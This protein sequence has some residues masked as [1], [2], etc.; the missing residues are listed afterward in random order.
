MIYGSCGC[1]NKGKHS[2]SM[3]EVISGIYRL[4]GENYLD[5]NN[6]EMGRGFWSAGQPKSG[7]K[8]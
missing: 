6:K 2:H 4:K 5:P 7:G 1:G 8:K 3:R